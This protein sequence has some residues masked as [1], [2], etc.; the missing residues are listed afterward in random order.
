[1]K[2]R[3]DL[4]NEIYQ[5]SNIADHIHNLLEHQHQLNEDEQFNTLIGIA[6]I[7]RNQSMTLLDTMCQVLKIDKYHPNYNNQ[8]QNYSQVEHEVEQEIEEQIEPV[9]EDPN[10]DPGPLRT[11]NIGNKFKSSIRSQQTLWGSAQEIESYLNNSV[12]S[13]KKASNNE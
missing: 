7:L 13:A 5:I 8:D 4:E 6:Q 9:E 1:M 10:T 3:F 11:D 2:D 12:Q